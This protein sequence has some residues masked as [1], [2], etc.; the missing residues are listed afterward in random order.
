M[1]Q[2]SPILHVSHHHD[3]FWEFS[4]F[5]SNIKEDE[6]LSVALEEIILLDPTVSDIADLPYGFKA[7]RKTKE[8]PWR[9]LNEK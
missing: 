5:E 6:I 7:V 9:I 2:N 3:G 8:S 4:G 1:R